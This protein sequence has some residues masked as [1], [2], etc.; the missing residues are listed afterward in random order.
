MNIEVKEDAAQVNV[1]V[2]GDIEMMTIKDFKEKLLNL[3]Q[4][5]ELLQ[6]HWHAIF[7]TKRRAKIHWG[8][9]AHVP[10]RPDTVTEVGLVE[11][12]ELIHK[13]YGSRSGEL[14][15]LPVDLED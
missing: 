1:I 4:G 5:T 15:F 9:I 10:L 6:V 14:A 13:F 7:E 11:M 8:K 3:G 12:F 2:N